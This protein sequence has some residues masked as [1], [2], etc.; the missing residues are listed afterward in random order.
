MKTSLQ[1]IKFQQKLFQSLV[2]SDFC[3]LQNKSLRQVSLVHSAIKLNSSKWI[4]SLNLLE[5]S[6]SLK[7]LI[8]L[9]Q[10]LKSQKNGKLLL[11]VDNKQHQHLLNELLQNSKQNH[12]FQVELDLFRNKAFTN[13]FQVLIALNQILT[14]NKKTLKYLFEQD[15]L[16]VTKINNLIETNNLTTYKIYNDLSDFKK[17]VFLIT[18][19]EQTL[20]T[21]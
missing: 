13:T 18:L 1:K 2:Q 10:F 20:N 15:I 6:K 7:Q 9:F 11:W 8:R 4:T 14:A 16:L 17:F 12:L 5:V 21:N 19:I 3:L